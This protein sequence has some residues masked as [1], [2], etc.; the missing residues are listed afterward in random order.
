MKK[1]FNMRGSN[2]ELNPRAL[3]QW[4]TN[5]CSTIRSQIFFYQN[6]QFEESRLK[7][8]EKIRDGRTN[9]QTDGQTDGQKDR[10]SLIFYVR[11]H[12]SQI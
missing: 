8:D 9:G 7:N 5:P 10:A 12:S 4:I 3:Q 6:R 2:S 1:K 11:Y